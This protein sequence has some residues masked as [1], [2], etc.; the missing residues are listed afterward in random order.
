LMLLISEKSKSL[1]IPGLNHRQLV[2][3]RMKRVGVF[4]EFSKI[5]K[6]V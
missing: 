1:G 6:N 3:I 2:C 4:P 5:L